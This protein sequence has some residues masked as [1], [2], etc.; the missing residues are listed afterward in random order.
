MLAL[1]ALFVAFRVKVDDPLDASA[2]TVDEGA[3]AAAGGGAGAGGGSS[4]GGEGGR[5][6]RHV[7]DD[8]GPIFPCVPPPIPVQDELRRM[9]AERIAA[10][11]LMSRL[12]NP[13]DCAR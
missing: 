1:T 4:S 8:L 6:V 11:T 5:K 13:R 12:Q 2:S 7:V 9:A 3:A 10:Q